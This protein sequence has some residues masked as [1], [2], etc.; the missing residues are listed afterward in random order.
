MFAPESL[1]WILSAKAL[2]AVKWY[3]PYP[4]SGHGVKFDPDEVLGRS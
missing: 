1:E 2:V 3:A 4:L